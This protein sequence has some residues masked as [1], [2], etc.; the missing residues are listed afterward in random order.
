M[1]DESARRQ[2]DIA[3]RIPP[4]IDEVAGRVAAE[5]GVLYIVGGWVRD[6]IRGSGGSEVDL[7]TDLNPDAMKRALENLGSIYDIGEK[8]GTVGLV[9]DGQTVEATTFRSDRYTPGSRHPEI[10]SVADIEEDLARRDFTINAI[11]LSVVPHRGVLVDPFDGVGDIRRRL[12]KTPGEPG[13]RMAEDPLRMMRAVRFAAQLSFRID[14]QLLAVLRK[15]A[16]LLDEISWERRRDELEK[17]LVARGA[18]DG[19]RTLVETGLMESV[20]PEVTAMRGVDQPRGY[21]RAD[22]LE[23]SL[24]TVGYTRPD[25]LL[26]RAALLHDVGKPQARV[27]EPRVMFPQHDRIATELTRVAMKRLRYGS[28]DLAKTTFLVRRHMRPMHYKGNWSEAAVRRLIRDCTLSKDNRTLV[29]L[30]A[31]FELARADIKAGNL[32]N[33]P[34]M[35]ELLEGLERRIAA[36]RG[37]KDIERPRSPLD[38][39]ELMEIFSRGQGPWI[40]RVK[41][42]LEHKVVL[43]QLAPGDKR[44][45]E[46]MARDLLER[47]AEKEDSGSDD[48][49]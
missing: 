26:R 19:L 6:A 4:L 25:P 35:M 45:A 23:H 43:G 17:I 22:V 5:G 9:S 13:P 48:D 39:R 11:A 40:S 10:S 1:G 41:R 3:S 21:H 37:R 7:A 14:G 2:L 49:G 12:I 32:D 34:A 44:A 28:E 33:V 36:V 30:S 24:L 29:P 16:A 42:Y 47:G 18:P 38:G 27:T 46:R 20:C 31:V 15:D 8:F